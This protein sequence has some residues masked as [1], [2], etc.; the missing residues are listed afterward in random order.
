MTVAL[1]LLRVAVLSWEFVVVLVAAVMLLSPPGWLA[2]IA[3]QVSQSNEVLRYV[4]LAPI[5][6][7]IFVF[8]EVRSI[9]LPAGDRRRW[10]QLWAEYWRLRM[11]C[12]TALF[13]GCLFSLAGLTTWVG[14]WGHCAVPRLIL[15][16]SGA[17][18]A[19]ITAA[20]IYL[21]RLNIDEE[22]ARQ[23][24]ANSTLEPPA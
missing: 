4:A 20:S 11:T 13:Y 21:A 3:A 19:A 24:G 1:E 16:L 8:R 6:L 22:F 14:E 5:A 7:T 18:G 12:L 10:L 2:P 15:Q 9:L 17:A 23:T